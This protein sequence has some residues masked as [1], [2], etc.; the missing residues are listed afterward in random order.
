MIC[1]VFVQLYPSERLNNL[2]KRLQHQRDDRKSDTSDRLKR[3]NW[4]EMGDHHQPVEMTGTDQSASKTFHV[5]SGVSALAP[6][7]LQRQRDALEVSVHVESKQFL[8]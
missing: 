5:A 1:D 7:S 8:F 3:E 4:V 6:L 2:L